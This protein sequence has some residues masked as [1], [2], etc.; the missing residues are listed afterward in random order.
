M[1]SGELYRLEGSVEA[2]I[3][4]NPDNGYSVLEIATD[5]DFLAAIPEECTGEFTV[6][7]FAKAAKIPRRQA[8]GVVKVLAERGIVE[9]T[10]KKGRAYLYKTNAQITKN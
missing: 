8:S 1:Q 9:R 10:G 3:Y 2:V 6:P 4:H 5:E 7:E